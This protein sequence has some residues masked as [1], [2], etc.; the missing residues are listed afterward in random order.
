MNVKI[1]F[2]MFVTVFSLQHSSLYAD[3][4]E[5]KYTL[6]GKMNTQTSPVANS[7]KGIVNKNEVE[8]TTPAR[9]WKGSWNAGQFVLPRNGKIV[10]KAE[11]EKAKA[12][13]V[14]QIY[15]GKVITK[16]D[17]LETENGELT[18]VW[19]ITSGKK[20]TL[21]TLWVTV[22]R[23]GDE[24]GKIKIKELS[25]WKKQIENKL[26]ADKQVAEL[27]VF[28]GEKVTQVKKVTPYSRDLDVVKSIKG[29][30]YKVDQSVNK[31][32]IWRHAA[33]KICLFSG[34]GTTIPIEITLPAGESGTLKVLLQ[35]A[36]PSEDNIA[37]LILTEKEAIKVAKFGGA[38]K[39]VDLT[40]TKADTAKGKLTLKVAYLKGANIN[41]KAIKLYIDK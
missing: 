4:A 1:M 2:L 3:D 11:L 18:A 20:R 31:F 19:N 29:Y 36:G 25:V 21:S 24:T 23:T 8:I 34:P 40:F 14:L 41:L 16:P 33:D 6:I 30:D 37:A 39:W 32:R 15:G 17:S 13:F 38:G 9:Y 12:K 27:S 10:L 35:D 22:W 28:F 7:G 26:E 5:S